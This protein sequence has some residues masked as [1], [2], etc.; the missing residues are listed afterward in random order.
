M[1]LANIGKPEFLCAF[2]KTSGA[3][4]SERIIEHGRWSK[5]IMNEPHSATDK[6]QNMDSVI[7]KLK[8][9]HLKD[10]KIL[11]LENKNLELRNEN[12]SLKH[13]L[14][15]MELNEKMKKQSLE[16]TNELRFITIRDRIFW[17]AHRFFAGV[18]QNW[19]LYDSYTEWY[20]SIAGLMNDKEVYVFDNKFHF[21]KKKFGGYKND[22]YLVS[23]RT[24]TSYKEHAQDVVVEG[25]GK[26]L[27][28]TAT[29]II[30]H[31]TNLCQSLEMKKRFQKDGYEEW[32]SSD[33]PTE[34]FQNNSAIFLI[35][36]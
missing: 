31:P 16:E 26:E 5:T 17:G 12:E 7:E 9:D 2:N 6:K 4:R 24:G 1:N 29:V 3:L 15:I 11:T 23:K 30:L 25:F 8:E 35:L 33:V 28:Q 20:Q 36:C 19:N 27:W 13:K 14:E 18:Y 34:I 10:I 22:L 21:V 32:Q